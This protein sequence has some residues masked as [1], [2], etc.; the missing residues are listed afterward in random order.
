LRA[1]GVAVD[2][3][4][5]LDTPLTKVEITQVLKTLKMRAI[6]IIRIKELAW[7]ESNLDENSS[8]GEIIALMVTHPCLIERPIIFNDNDAII[9]RPLENVTK[10][11]NSQTI[12]R[13][14]S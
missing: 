14:K 1:Q 2:I 9:G 7:V 11:M 4:N 12:C 10:F 8:D 5:Y 6:E 13:Q 3:I